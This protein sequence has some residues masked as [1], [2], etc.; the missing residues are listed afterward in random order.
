M[1]VFAGLDEVAAAV[2][3]SIGES[4]W[5]TVDQ[6]RIDAFAGVTGDPQWIHVDPERA[7]A[8]P[9]GRTIAHGYLTLSLVTLFLDETF[10]VEGAGMAVNY[11][12]DRVRFPAP[13][14]VDARV[15][16]RVEFAD[17]SETARGHLLRSTVTVD[18]EGSDRPACVAEI[19]T[20]YP[21]A[22]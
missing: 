18:I 22:D 21:K 7:A 3:T 9:F 19:L 10:R 6:E 17:L 14:P 4:G 5:H 15:R 12:A 11:G 2:G 8:G 1:R 13:V 20:F 16:G